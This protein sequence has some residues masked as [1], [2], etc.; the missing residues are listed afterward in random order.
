MRCSVR[1][2]LL[3]PP[4]LPSVEARQQNRRILFLAKHLEVCLYR[5][6]PSLEAYIDRDTL[7]DRLKSIARTVASQR[8]QNDQNQILAFHSPSVVRAKPCRVMIAKSMSF[9][10]VCLRSAECLSIARDQWNIQRH[11]RWSTSHSIMLHSG[12]T[13]PGFKMPAGSNTCLMAR[14]RASV[15]GS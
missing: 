13:L 15:C 4:N 9:T 2:E 5:D 6:A 3:E 7:R 8:Q 1:I 11:S 12:N 14:I 10:A